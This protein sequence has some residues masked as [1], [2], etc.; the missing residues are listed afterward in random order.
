MS[1]LELEKLVESLSE[2]EKAQL[3]KLLNRE[4]VETHVPDLSWLDAL[5]AEV[6]AAWEKEG[7]R[8]DIPRDWAQNFD[9][10]K[11]NHFRREE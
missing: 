3:Q 2:A 8:P 11:E 5:Q 10:Y 6:R 1:V 7:P 4:A 9:Q